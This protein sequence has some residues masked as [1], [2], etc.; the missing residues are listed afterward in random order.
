MKN[1][2]FKKNPG[3]RHPQM[4]SVNFNERYCCN[5]IQQLKII[6]PF[7]WAAR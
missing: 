5:T 6:C 4:S 2:D 7:N 3:K 1:D